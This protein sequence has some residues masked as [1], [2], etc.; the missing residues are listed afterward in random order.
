MALAACAHAALL[1]LALQ[2]APGR[3]QQAGAAQ[4]VRVQGAVYDSIVGTPIAGARVHF[5]ATSEPDA[6]R[7]FS[8]LSDEAGR[9]VIPGLPPGDYVAGFESLALDTLG[10]EPGTRLVQ[11]QPG[12]P[13][14]NFATPSPPALILAICGT[15]AND[16]TALLIGHVRDADTEMALFPA[17]VAVEWVETVVDGRGVRTRNARVAGAAGGPGFFAICDLP[18][19]AA[20][21]AYATHGADSSGFV[22]VELPPAGVRYVRFYVGVTTGSSAGAALL[23]PDSVAAPAGAVAPEGARLS[24]RV[25]GEDGSPIVGAYVRLWNSEIE[26]STTADGRFSL[27]GLPGGTH[28]VEARALGYVPAT[29]TVHLAAGRPLA[30]DVRF[31]QRATVLRPIEVRAQLVYSRHLQ[32]FESRRRVGWGRYITPGEIEARPVTTLSRLLEG[33]PGIW[34]ERGRDGTLV[35]MRAVGAGVR[36]CTPTLWVDGMRDQVNDFDFLHSDRVAAVEVY[37]RP[38]D[39]PPRFSYA[40]EC[41]AIIVWTRPIPARPS[42]REPRS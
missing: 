25:V 37:A 9:Y 27:A 38:L 32:E 8:A 2:P 21:H 6:G 36:Y 30:V 24:G 7:T 42:E 18:T 26:A 15:E 12:M 34:L 1:M 19:D 23:A 33:Y 41:G 40:K 29:A 5:V 4:M 35:R 16:S 17:V 28:T 10:I 13:R 3:A 11:V 20:L 14:V 39:V 31:S 22:E